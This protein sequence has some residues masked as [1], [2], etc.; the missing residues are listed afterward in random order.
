MARLV[1]RLIELTGRC[2]VLPRRD[3][4][5]FPGTRERFEN[6]LIGVIGRVADQHLGGHLRQQRVG[7]D[8]I[9]GLSWGQQE[10]QRVAERVDQSVDFG[11]QSALAA[12]DRLIVIFFGCAG[13]VLV[14]AYDG[15]VN[16][17]IFIVGLGGQVLEEAL[18]C[19][20]LGP[21]AEPLVRALPVAKPFPASRAKEFQRG[22]R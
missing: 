7:A 13:T 10:A 5:G 3:D 20:F 16:H 4:G 18:P 8:Q 22:K 9:I 14:G 11:A 12:A 6:T 21:A 19:P 17:R 2:S 1:E 15:A